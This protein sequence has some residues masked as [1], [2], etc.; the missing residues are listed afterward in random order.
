MA[1]K[2]ED[3]SAQG[4][5]YQGDELLQLVRNQSSDSNKEDSRT[6]S[7]MKAMLINDQDG[8]Q[9]KSGVAST[10]TANQNI[11]VSVT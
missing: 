1:V 11:E 9:G 5:S 10:A 3:S 7:V 8:A 4:E 6:G 2:L